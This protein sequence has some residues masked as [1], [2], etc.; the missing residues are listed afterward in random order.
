MHGYQNLQISIGNEFSITTNKL[1]V[2]HAMNNRR[3]LCMVLTLHVY[4]IG[5]DYNFQQ[6]PIVCGPMLLRGWSP[7]A[8][9]M[10]PCCSEDGPL[11]FRG[12]SP[13]AQRMV[14]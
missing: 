5:M 1:S 8:Q 7:A 2:L 14:P 6:V 11:L 10:V 4:I 12:W 13:A 3:T 9:K